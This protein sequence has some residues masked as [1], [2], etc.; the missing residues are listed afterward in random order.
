MTGNF[1]GKPLGSHNSSLLQIESHVALC[2][3]RHL[4]N[5]GQYVLVRQNEHEQVDCW[6]V[7]QVHL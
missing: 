1:V 5:M 2:S 4:A 3:I 6:L 7:R